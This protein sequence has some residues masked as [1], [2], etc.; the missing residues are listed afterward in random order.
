MILIS[1]L[2]NSLKLFV[3]SGVDFGSSVSQES[4]PFDLKC[5]VY[6]KHGGFCIL[7]SVFYLFIFFWWYCG[8]TL[9]ALY[10]A[11]PLEPQPFL[12]LVI[13]NR[14]SP[15]PG[16]VLHCDVPPHPPKRREHK[17]DPPC[18]LPDILIRDVPM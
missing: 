4:D 18:L 1:L 10:C 2:G 14:A 15:L 17:H 13:L 11:L 16:S 7:H 5:Q 9:R 6:R 12:L 3:K 8:V